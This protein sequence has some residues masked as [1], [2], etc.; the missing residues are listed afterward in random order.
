MTVKEEIYSSLNHH[1]FRDDNNDILDEENDV[2]MDL[3]NSSFNNTQ[4]EDFTNEES[5][6]V[7]VELDSEG[8]DDG[9]RNDET[10]PQG[11]RYKGTGKTM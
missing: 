7:K 9:M 11:W 1:E 4:G 3:L 8:Q 5:V 6:S 2:D 10:V